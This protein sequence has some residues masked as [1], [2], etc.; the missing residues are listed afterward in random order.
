[1]LG[2]ALEAVPFSSRVHPDVSGIC[3]GEAQISFSFSRWAWH[4]FEPVTAGSDFCDSDART[5]FEAVPFSPR[6]HR[7][8]QR[9][10]M[11]KRRF[12][13]LSHDGP[14]ILSSLLR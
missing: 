4:T 6:M 5:A 7:M 14:G 8:S 13:L 12:R 11:G 3:N 2:A 9:Y 1:M 10:A